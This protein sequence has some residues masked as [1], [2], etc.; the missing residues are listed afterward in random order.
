MDDNKQKKKIDPLDMVFGIACLLVIAVLI[1]YWLNFKNN[2][3]SSEVE[4]WG[5]FGDYVGGTINPILGFL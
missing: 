3:I 2:P 4:N 1:I 5:S